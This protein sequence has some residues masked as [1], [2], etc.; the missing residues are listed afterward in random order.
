[1]AQGIKSSTSRPKRQAMFKVD[2]EEAASRKGFEATFI[3][4]T[5]LPRGPCRGQPSAK[6]LRQQRE[7]GKPISA[8][9]RRREEPQVVRELRELKGTSSI[10]KPGPTPTAAK[11]ESLQASPSGRGSTTRKTWT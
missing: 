11:G 9:L 7:R 5:S 1:M 8:R 6:E 10:R 3:G 2:R 4:R